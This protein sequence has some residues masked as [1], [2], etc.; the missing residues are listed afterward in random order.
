[1]QLNHTDFNGQWQFFVTSLKVRISLFW[2]YKNGPG[3]ICTG[4]QQEFWL[5]IH[6][7]VMNNKYHSPDLSK[8]QID[9]MCIYAY[10]TGSMDSPCQ[11]VCEKDSIEACRSHSGCKK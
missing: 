3:L 5:K 8:N 9:N 7:L 10:L 4:Q 2:L 1:M 11:L 6:T